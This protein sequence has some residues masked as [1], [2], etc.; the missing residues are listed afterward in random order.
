MHAQIQNQVE[1]SRKQSD[2]FVAGI[3]PDNE[4]LLWSGRPGFVGTFNSHELF[5]SIIITAIITVIV[6]IITGDD[7]FLPLEAKILF[8]VTTCAM[9]LLLFGWFRQLYRYFCLTI[10]MYYAVTESR[11]VVIKHKAILNELPL[12]AVENTSV[13]KRLWGNGTVVF[14]QGSDY[15]EQ[16]KMIEA[17]TNKPFCFY[18]VLDPDNVID[19]VRH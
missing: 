6:L 15:F 9:L 11:L 16:N 10:G 19:L 18:N 12:R 14:N 4:K 8:S 1:R 2:K 13:H 3:L 17:P 7:E 5:L